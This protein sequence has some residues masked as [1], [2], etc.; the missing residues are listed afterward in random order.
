MTSKQAMETYRWNYYKSC[1]DESVSDP[2][3]HALFL[4]WIEARYGKP[5]E[6][7]DMSITINLENLM[8]TAK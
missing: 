6:K 1:A 3:E 4:T 2:V 5:V 8:E 7:L